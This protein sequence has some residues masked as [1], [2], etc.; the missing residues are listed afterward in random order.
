MTFIQDTLWDLGEEA[1]LAQQAGLPAQGGREAA[2]RPV[3]LR[4][5]FHPGPFAA[6][7]FSC[8]ISLQFLLSGSSSLVLALAAHLRGSGFARRAG[9]A[10]ACPVLSQRSWEF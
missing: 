8:R 1:E 3:A 7:S 10:Q 4:P 6:F 2:H 9:R 5:P